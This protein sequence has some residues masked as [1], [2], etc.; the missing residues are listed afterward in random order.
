[1]TTSDIPAPI[2]DRTLLPTQEAI[3]AVTRSGALLSREAVRA[4]KDGCF[5]D[6]SI[7]LL[8]RYGLLAAGIPCEFGG[9]GLDA[10]SLSAIAG[11]L[12]SYCGSTG[13]IWAM[14]HIQVACLARCASASP[15]IADYLR[16]VAREQHLIA[17]VT[18]EAG[19]GGDLR[20]SR[21]AL[22]Q[23]DERTVRLEKQATTVSYGAQADSF[24]ITVRRNEDAAP[25]DQVLVLAPTTH[26]RLEQTGNWNMLG[27]RGTCSPP[28]R[29]SAV[30]PSSYVLPEP[31]AHI[32]SR[33]MVPLSH[34]LWSSV[35]TGIAADAAKRAA[36]YSRAAMRSAIRSD[37]YATDHRLGRIYRQ[38]A[39]IRDSVHRFSADYARWDQAGSGADDVEIAIRANALKASVSTG[40]TNVAELA[41]QICGMAGYS[42][43]GEYSVT[44]QLRDLHSSA[45]MISNFRLETAN[46]QLLLLREAEFHP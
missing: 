18:S 25:G 14:H 27:M 8:R 37:S 5:P 28:F 24:L 11:Q 15:A 33:C 42:E 3:D 22:V 36:A 7:E 43:E 2:G 41:L 10:E 9:H 6:Q 44:R 39:Q 13:M 31:F 21:A 38:L 40:A 23:A 20:R 12:A 45:L 32:A 35:W 26:A 19:V 1:M 16:A 30:I 34:L 46:S 17:S 29:V 4:D